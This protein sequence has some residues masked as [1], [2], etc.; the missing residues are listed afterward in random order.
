MIRWCW[1]FLLFIARVASRL[2]R[3]LSLKHGTAHSNA[4]PRHRN[5]N[6]IKKS[7]QLEMFHT[8][9]K[10]DECALT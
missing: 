8:S 2:S 5:E 10:Y 3:A 4:K 9:V 7:Y 6:A 1:L